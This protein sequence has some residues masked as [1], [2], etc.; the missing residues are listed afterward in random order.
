M[1]VKDILSTNSTIKNYVNRF[2]DLNPNSNLEYQGVLGVTFRDF[3]IS[4]PDLKSQINN[5]LREKGLY[6]K[7]EIK[8]QIVYDFFDTFYNENKRGPNT[9]ELY[10]TF[11]NFKSHEL[12]GKINIIRKNYPHYYAEE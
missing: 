7:G 4:Q 2:K 5:C 3:L 6:G 9:F 10:Q 8:H 1:K 11:L 12:R